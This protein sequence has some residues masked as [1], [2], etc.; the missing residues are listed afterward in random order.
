MQ[1]AKLVT[2]RLQDNLAENHLLHAEFSFLLIFSC[3][4][5]VE[6]IDLIS[7]NGFFTLVL[8]ISYSLPKDTD[9]VNYL[10]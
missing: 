10:E 8:P 4:D 2:K 3:V 9:K 7:C 1:L 6:L 5:F